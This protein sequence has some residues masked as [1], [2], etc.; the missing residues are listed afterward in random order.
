MKLKKQIAAIYGNRLRI[1]VCGIC[2]IN[3]KILLLKHFFGKK[4][5]YSW[6]PPGGGVEYGESVIEALK[7]EFLEE[8]GLIVLVGKLMFVNEFISNPYH[9]VELIFSVTK[10]GGKLFKGFDPESLRKQQIIKE[11]RFLSFSEINAESSSKKH[12]LFRYCTSIKKLKAMQGIY[13]Y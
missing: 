7:R 12:N 5:H 2:I 13:F 8:T 9:A 10:K 11:I 3:K 4:S 6:L 1:R